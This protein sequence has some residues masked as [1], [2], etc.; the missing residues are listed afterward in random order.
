MKFRKP[1]YLMTLAAAVL[2]LSACGKAQFAK[3]DYQATAIA[4]Q[5]VTTKPKIDVIVFQDNS[6]S[7]MYG[8]IE[9]LKPQMNA[10]L[11]GMSSQWD[12][13]FTVLPLLSQ[14]SVTGKYVVASNCADISGTTGC[15]SP[16]QA[17]TFNNSSGDYGWIRSTL[18]GIGSNDKGFYNMYAN[19][20]HSSMTSTGFL[21]SD[22]ALAIIVLS[23]GED[24]D[25]MTYYDRGDGYQ[26]LD[27]NSGV[28]TYN[29]YRN[30]FQNIK[31][32]SSLRRFY[33]VVS[34]G[35]TCYNYSSIRGQRYMNMADDLG[36]RS[37]NLCNGELSSSLASMKQQLVA[38][39]E[40]VQFNYVV[41]DQKPMVSSI[42]VKKNGV[43]IPQS[44][45]NGWS[46]VGYLSNQPTS[47][48]PTSGN[49]RTG[50]FIKLNG[51]AVYKGSDQI[52]ID[53][54]KE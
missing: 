8:P 43:T 46:Y 41:M 23:N 18:S 36:S 39:A 24:I 26:Q 40:A 1:T 22:A 37:Y 7:V 5:Y 45:S 29:S 38:V 54:Q 31:P 32:S 20:Q 51:S 6:D 10:F 30:Y 14:K 2:M 3:Q 19:L 47:Y 25:G 52:S 9:T 16:S 12:L 34:P 21:R 42:V 48:A 27:Y 15:L 13:H 28:S 50:Y 17:S 53:F 49:I 44:S 4:G 33:S 35:G 11:T